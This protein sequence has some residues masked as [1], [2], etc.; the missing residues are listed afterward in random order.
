MGSLNPENKVDL[1]NPQYTVVVEIIKTVCCLSVVRDYVL[2]R[3]YNL[4]EVVK[5]NKEDAQQ[6][7]SSLTEEQKSDVVKAE[8]E[9]EEKNSKE[10]KEKN[11]SETKSEST[12]NDVDSVEN[13]M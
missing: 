7:P 11:Q 9:E 1:N 12:G 3:K 2:F 13:V 10:V 4:Q 6:N 8:A 5:S